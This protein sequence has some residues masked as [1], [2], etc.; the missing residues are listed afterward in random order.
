V[1]R[2]GTVFV[3]LTGKGEKP[4]L[5]YSINKELGVMELIETYVPPNLRGRGLAEKLVDE[6]IKYAEENNLKIE[7]VCSYAFYYFIK[8]KDKRK[9]L[10]DWLQEK[11]D[12]ELEKL[13]E[14]RR[15]LELSK[16]K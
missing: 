9:L 4:F 3:I 5:R 16:T 1:K 8:N 12:E 7:P 14:Y 6:A 13:F 10:V 11:S 15:S 2:T